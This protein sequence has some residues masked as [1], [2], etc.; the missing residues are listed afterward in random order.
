VG[1]DAARA[2]SLL[3]SLGFAAGTPIERAG[4]PGE[5]G[6]VVNQIP[7]AGTPEEEGATLTLIIGG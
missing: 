6:K 5:K 3:R 2:D 7:E 4:P 1:L